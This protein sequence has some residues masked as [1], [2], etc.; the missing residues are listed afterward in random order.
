MNFEEYKKQ[1]I[2]NRI[3]FK[4][5]IKSIGFKKTSKGYNGYEYNN[6]TIYLY[7]VYYNFRFSYNNCFLGSD[8]NDYK[9]LR[10]FETH[11]KKE[12][13]SIKLKKLLNGL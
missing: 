8:R 12:L 7:D 5:Y 9:D 11:F 1:C 6:Y 2:L 13:R 10:F 4:K 3:I